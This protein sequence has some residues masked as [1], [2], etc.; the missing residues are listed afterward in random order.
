M[1]SWS[2]P[3]KNHHVSLDIATVAPALTQRRFDSL[4]SARRPLFSL[5]ASAQLVLSQTWITGLNGGGSTK[6]SELFMENG[7]ENE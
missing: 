7:M 5:A 1:F 3:L 6:I 2:K 4:G